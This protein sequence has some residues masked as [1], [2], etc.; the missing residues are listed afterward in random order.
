M[1]RFDLQKALEEAGLV[2]P[3]ARQ[4]AEAAGGNFT[5]LRRR[6]SKTADPAP[7]ARDSD[8]APLLLA[9]AWDDRCIGD[10]QVVSELAGKKYSDVQTL[11]KKW[12]SEPDPPVRFVLETWEFLSPVDAWEALHHYLTTSQL[13]SFELLAVDVLGE[14]NPALDLPP[15]ERFMAA[16]KGKLWRHSGA[17]RRG[18]AEILALGATREQEGSVGTELRIADRASNIIRK[19][20]P[21]GCDWQRWASLG[22]L[23]PLLM[24]AAPEILLEA[25][26]VDIS[27][28]SPQLVELMKLET[29]G[30]V[31]GTIYHSGVLWAQETAA[32]PK[33]RFQRVSLSLARLANLDPGG[34][35]SNRPFAS[36][37]SLFFSWRPQTVASVRERIETLHFLQQKEPEQIWKIVLKLLPQAHESISDNPKPSYRSWAAGWTGEITRRDYNLFISELSSMAVTMAEAESARWPDLLEHVAQLSPNDFQKAVSGLEKFAREPAQEPLRTNV[38]NKLRDIVQKHTYFHDAWWALPEAQITKLASLQEKFTPSDLVAVHSPLF[39][40]DGVMEGDKSETYE[41]KQER[42]EN[43][44]RSAIRVMW[45]TCGEKAEKLIFELAQKV[46]QPWS[47][48]WSLAAELGVEVED[49]I[50]PAYLAAGDDPVRRCTAAFVSQRIRVNGQDWAEKRPGPSWTPDQVA[51]WALQMSFEPRTW[52]WVASRGDAV[53]Q[54]YWSQTGAWGHR[55]L[56]LPARSRAATELQTVARAWSALQLLMQAKYDKC[57]LSHTVVCD[58]LEAVAAN[59]TERTPGTMDVHYVHEA[60]EFLQNCRDADEARVAR[61]EFNFLPFLDRHSRLP[62]TLQRQLA[63]D[64]D[65][66]LECLVLLYRPRHEVKENADEDSKERDDPEKAA[67][68]KRIWR[69]LHDWRTIP[70]T[71]EDGKVSTDALKAWMRSARQKAREV[72]RLEVCDLILGELFA[73]SVTDTDGAKPVIAIREVIEEFESKELENG[74]AVGLHNLRGCYSKSL[75]E[76]GKQE[77]ELASEFKRYATVCARWP[78]TAAVLRGVAEDYQRQAEREDERAQTWERLGRS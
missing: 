4:I 75:Y 50:V 38:W 49:K 69:L 37:I 25:I 16:V 1:R 8:L 27:S 6:F 54:L 10:Q 7:W 26:E 41:Q 33:E 63:K 9:A 65:F 34:T 59:P 44:R 56:D 73:H 60:F 71:G 2:D 47:V 67:K 55:N 24:E 48:G 36:L 30:G 13:E 46:R 19:L 32:W 61:L 35:W 22:D 5:I 21:I 11:M 15:D 3:E 29:P 70:G 12:R 57:P 76:G 53:K 18:I 66:F 31:M 23:L 51:A 74:L 64:T 17:L 40:D 20:L 43:E 39:D 72:D 45:T 14:N 62:L 42:R 28:K 58:A 52:D 68:A 77:R 78:R